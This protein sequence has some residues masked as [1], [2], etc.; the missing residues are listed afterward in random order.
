LDTTDSST[1][2]APVRRSFPR[3]LIGVGLLAVGVV[4]QTFF[5]F[6]FAE[7]PTFFKMSFLW[8]WPATL[9]AFT[10]WWLFASGLSWRVKLSP[11]IGLVILFGVFASVFRI[12]GSDGD[13]VPRL[14]YRWSPTPESKA[15]DYWTR[16]PTAAESSSETAEEP[17]VAGPDDWPDYHGPNR[18]GIIRGRGFRTDWDARPPKELWRHPVGLAWS[19][20]SVLGDYAI[21]QEQRDG[22]ECVVAYSLETGDQKWVHAD[23]ARF[24]VVAVNGGDGPRS[25]PVIAGD[26]TYSLGATGIV[27]GL[28][29]RTGKRLWSRNAL[30]DAG[31]NGK[32]ADNLQWGLSG[33]PLVVDGKVIVIAGGT[34]GKSVIAYD[35]ETGDIAW[36]G[37][38]FP[39]SYGGARVEEIHGVRQV[40]AFHGTGIAAF[41]LEDGRLLWSHP[42]ENMPKVNVAQPLRT[43]DDT[44]VIGSGYSVGA[45][46]LTLA[47]G[48]DRDW[49]VSPGWT[50]NRF[51]LKFNDAVLLGGYAYGLDDGIM[52]C[53]DV[54]TGKT[55]WKGGRF[56]YGQLIAFENTLLVLS[57]E[58]DAV[59]VAAQ[60]T[61]FEERGRVHVLDGTT[62]NHPAV[63]HGKLLVRNGTE[64]ACYDVAP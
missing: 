9:F 5:A 26:R 36:A 22:D 59:L 45:I 14:S 10:L 43:A 32:P 56:G 12:D 33:A 63:A 2:P 35:A 55:K 48:T 27:N 42:W 57:E 30:E 19:S 44:L 37:G 31:E 21:T 51:K 54:A 38:N 16:L 11:L 17:L 47:G 3:W 24:T 52:T 15:R 60:P 49:S 50:S 8:V 41:A 53:L 40:L 64:A 7:D 18:E 23:P 1:T 20:F 6:R 62:W 4:A 61:K 34:A 13:M 39:A 46:Q 58:G 25:T 29:T 28:E